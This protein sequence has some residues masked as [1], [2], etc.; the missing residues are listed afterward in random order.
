MKSFGRRIHNCLAPNEWKAIIKYG[1]ND[2]PKAWIPSANVLPLQ[3]PRGKLLKTMARQQRLDWTQGE[4]YMLVAVASSVHVSPQQLQLNHLPITANSLN[5]PTHPNQSNKLR[6]YS[7]K[8]MYLDH[9]YLSST[10]T[11]ARKFHSLIWH[12]T[13]FTF[14]CLNLDILQSYSPPET[15]VPLLQWHN[16]QLQHRG[17]HQPLLTVEMRPRQGF[18]RQVPQAFH[19]GSITFVQT[20]GA[21]QWEAPYKSVVKG[22]QQGH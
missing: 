1:Q 19:E 2:P 7:C 4:F 12:L 22:R 15:R 14:D 21:Q 11:K 3:E 5:C 18:V 17:P 6:C 16:I 20:W 10:V 13:I 8:Y 9:Q